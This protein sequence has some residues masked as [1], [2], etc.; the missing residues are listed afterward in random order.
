M[1]VSVSPVDNASV[2]GPTVVSIVIVLANLLAWALNE[3]SWAYRHLLSRARVPK[4]LFIS[5]RCA[6]RSP[7]TKSCQHVLTRSKEGCQPIAAAG[8]KGRCMHSAQHRLYACL[9]DQLALFC[10]SEPP[11]PDVPRAEGVPKTARPQSYWAFDLLDPHHL[12]R[13][14][15]CFVLAGQHTHEP[16]S[17][18][19]TPRYTASQSIHQRSQQ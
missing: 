12:V 15:S 11:N 17:A 10:T 19:A 18:H 1:S 9:G 5:N 3:H 2:W 8:G 14:S 4:L 16:T 13:R 6:G 7:S